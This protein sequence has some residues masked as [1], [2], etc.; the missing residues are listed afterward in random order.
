MVV[1]VVPVVAQ[2]A[3]RQ[4]ASK[5]PAGAAVE[6]RLVGCDLA[7]GIGACGCAAPLG[8][9]LGGVPFCFLMADALDVEFRCEEEEDHGDGRD[10]DRGMAGTRQRHPQEDRDGGDQREA[11]EAELVAGCQANETEIQETRAA[12]VP[13]HAPTA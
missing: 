5:T 3:S 9:N 4:D 11:G 13:D 7:L 10:R 8:Q 1:A 2:P 12:R 6:R